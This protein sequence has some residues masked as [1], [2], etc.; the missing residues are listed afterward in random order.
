M[1]SYAQSKLMQVA[2]ARALQ[3]HFDAEV[4]NKRLVSS[5]EPGLVQSNLLRDVSG[6]PQDPA[7]W[8][9]AKFQPIV[10]LDVRQGSATGVHLATSDSLEVLH[11][12]GRYFDR[13]R[14][15][16]HTADG[17]SKEMLDRL[18]TRWSADCEVSVSK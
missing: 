12:G 8:I 5:W 10:G 1:A 3:A 17:Y 11:N 13:M 9:L 14:A 15:R 2:Y 16:A 4:D 7:T 18:V 6:G